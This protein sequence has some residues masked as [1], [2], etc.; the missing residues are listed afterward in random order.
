MDYIAKGKSIRLSGMPVR[1]SENSI[2][3]FKVSNNNL[4]KT[5]LLRLERLF[6]DDRKERVQLFLAELLARSGLYK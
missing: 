5:A 2:V 3:D 4:S 6:T 1:D